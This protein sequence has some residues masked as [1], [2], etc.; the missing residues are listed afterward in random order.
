MSAI[1][2]VNVILLRTLLVGC[3]L[4][5]L[6]VP[7]QGSP[8]LS[9]EGLLPQAAVLVV[10]GQRKLVRVG[11]SFGGVTVI[12]ASGES[13]T[14]EVDGQQQVLGLSQ[15]I[16]SNFVAPTRDA[17]SIVRDGALQYRTSALI[18]DRSTTVLVDTGANIM[19]LS[20]GHAADLGIDYRSGEASKV[21]TASGLA[22][23]YRV[24]LRSVAVGGIRVENVE[25][26][27]IEG[28]YP[29]TV[30]LGMTYLRH[31]TLEENN[32]IL[33]LSRMR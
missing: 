31:V 15:R 1:L 28:D 11:Q 33:S 30:L 17:V 5:W 18:N 27:V 9:V 22:N 26:A 21:Q 24:T 3:S 7:L 20:T 14:I 12:A 16:D 4:L 10:N 23:A 8:A 29:S 32:G 6:S 2:E 25:A 13:V 19:A